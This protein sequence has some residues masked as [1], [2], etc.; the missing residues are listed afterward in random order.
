MTASTHYAIQ[1]EWSGGDAVDYIELGTD[2]SSP[3]H[4]GNAFAYDGDFYV[5]YSTQDQCF[6]V[7]S[8]VA[9]Y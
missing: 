8:N 7:Y 6:V 9:N 4:G 3:T 5:E 1:L 2:A